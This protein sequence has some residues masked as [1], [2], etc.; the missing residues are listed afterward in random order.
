MKGMLAV[1]ITCIAIGTISVAMTVT[2][3]HS[4]PSAAATQDYGKR[5]IAQT[6][7]FLGPDVTDTR[8]RLTASRLACASCHLG[9]GEE[10]GN[11]SLASAMSRYPRI[12]P[13]VGGN[14][15]IE[16]RIN[17]CMVRSMNGRP[18]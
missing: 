4:S 14:E 10:P 7:E 6:T 16:D 3:R 17:G 18:L 9:A 12:S 5:L 13:R 2:S 11:L 8:M 1:L 15:T